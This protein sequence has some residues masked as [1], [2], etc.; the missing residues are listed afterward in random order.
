MRFVLDAQLPPA[1]AAW[2]VAE[3]HDAVHVF[4]L[5]LT[6]A[7][8]ATIWQHARETDAIIV[9]KDEDFA[10]LAQLRPSGPAV[11][12][13]RVGNTRKAELIRRVAAA[14]PRVVE[15]LQRGESLTELV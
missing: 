1:L 11:V 5:G 6:R 9:T 13:I 12:W 7:G 4:A 8:D 15:A 3:G 2:L 14:W 10:L